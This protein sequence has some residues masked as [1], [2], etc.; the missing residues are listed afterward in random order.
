M[1]LATSSREAILVRKP[2]AA[3]RTAR[4]SDVNRRSV[5]H[6][7]RRSIASRVIWWRCCSR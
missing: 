1:P 2:A 3:I 7:S 6:M 4:L 5:V